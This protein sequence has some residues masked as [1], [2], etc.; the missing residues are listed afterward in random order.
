MKRKLISANV[1]DLPL[2]GLAPINALFRF[3]F[4]ALLRNRG[5]KFLY[6]RLGKCVSRTTL[7]VSCV[8][9][10]ESIPPLSFLSLN[11]L[12]SVKSSFLP[13]IFLVASFF[14]PLGIFMIDHGLM[15]RSWKRE[16]NIMYRLIL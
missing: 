9:S 7:I 6:A 2:T 15:F 11:S 16:Y 3:H 13:Q 8:K 10:S 14:F 12:W 1:I 5:A 4:R